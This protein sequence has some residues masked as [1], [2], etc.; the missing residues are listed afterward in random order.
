[1]KRFRKLLA[2]VVTL[3]LVVVLL[4]PVTALA[5]TS[6]ATTITGNPSAAV[7]I[8]VSPSVSF[9][10]AA[11]GTNTDTSSSIVVKCN[12]DWNIGVTGDTSS[13]KTYSGN[14]WEWDASK[15]GYVASPSG[16]YLSANMTVQT[17]NTASGK[18][19]AIVTV[20]TGGNLWSSNPIYTDAV[21]AGTT[22]TMTLTQ[23][24]TYDDPRL[25][26]NDYRIVITYTASTS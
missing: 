10:L 22:Y 5:G 18:A 19:K 11:T 14:M 9:T 21:N 23:A 8:S 1:M 4:V 24:T 6:G 2:I 17:V 25:A 12:T 13:N 15:S 7:D 20:G 26:S 3:A 16:K